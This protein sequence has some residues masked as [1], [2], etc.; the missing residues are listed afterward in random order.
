MA[1]KETQLVKF[2]LGDDS[3]RVTYSYSEVTSH[4]EATM[5]EVTRGD[6]SNQ[7]LNLELNDEPYSSHNLDSYFSKGVIRDTIKEESK[8]WREDCADIDEI[9]VELNGIESKLMEK[10]YE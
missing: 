10:A 1:Y 8:Y 4:R 7:C 2:Q 6:I 9:V 3:I 5:F